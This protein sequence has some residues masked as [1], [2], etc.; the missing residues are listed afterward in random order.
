MLAMIP[1]MLRKLQSQT[2]FCLVAILVLA[3]CTDPPK[4]SN[5]SA[6]TKEEA[7]PFSH[8]TAR[9]SKIGAEACVQC[10]ADE[11]EAWQHSHH[12]KANRPISTELDALAFSPTRQIKESGVTYQLSQEKD[13]FVLTVLQADGTSSRYPLIGV[14]GETPL[15]QYLAKMP[16]NKLQTISATYD[17]INDRWIDVFQ[18]EDRIPGEWGHWTGQG[19]NWNANCAY[20]HT[21]EYEK[22]FDYQG[23]AYH[24]TWV[25]QGIA[26][27]ECHSGLEEHV[28]AAKAGDYQRGLT[29]LTTQQT[30]HNCVS[31]HSRRDELTKDAFRVGDNF[32]DHF[33]LSLPDQPGLYHPDGKILEEVFVYGSF[34]MSRMAHAGV[35]C[36]DC[37]NPHTLELTLPTEN[38]MLC[39]RC[40]EAGGTL[41]A[42]IIQPTA[43]SFHAEGSTGNRCIECHMPKTTYMQVDPRADHGYH[44]PDPLMTQE[45][46]IPNACSN[47]H[48]DQTL[49]WVVEHAEARHG[50][51]LSDSRQRRRALAIADAYAGSPKAVP[52]LLKLAEDED[53]PAWRATYTGLLSNYLPDATVAEYLKAQLDDESQL[54]RERA[55][56]AMAMIEGGAD[57]LIEKLGDASR[58]VRISAARTLTIMGLTIPDDSAASEWKTYLEFN[59]DRPQSLLILAQVAAR[60]NRSS[61]VPQLLQRAV[62]L[63]SANPG[64]YHQGA[65]IL[66]AAGL[67]EAA[68]QYLYTGWE[69]APN[70]AQ[71]PYSLGLLAAEDQDL[72]TAVG[73]LEE[74]VAME[75]GFYRAWYNLSLAYSRLNQPEKASAAMQKAQGN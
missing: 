39:M 32:H 71:F 44:M 21:T 65:I 30:E 52:A 69:L 24:S 58:S 74:T 7:F 18:G 68:R 66:S 36:M 27:A 72:K 55:V 34:E 22:A 8:D 31:C 50:E 64:M 59:S 9:L 28:E 14:I 15:R 25:Q 19:M 16:G 47:C 51:K 48:S 3:G 26:C 29:Q 67:N 6:E 5:P 53:I 13:E 11:V 38:N 23:N 42:P 43:H 4:D 17:V 56:K 20:C 70:D 60:N 12:A 2:I 46:G 41:N 61:E 33:A 10:H 40:H 73:F 57:A 1:Y 37:H 45:L 75:P 62:Q 49:D 35:S 63:D 54:V